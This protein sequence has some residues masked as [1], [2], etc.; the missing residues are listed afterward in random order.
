MCKC[1]HNV[2]IAFS[3]GQM[4]ILGRFYLLKI[5]VCCLDFV[6]NYKSLKVLRIFH[7]RKSRC[8]ITYIE[9]TGII[10]TH[11]QISC[12]VLGILKK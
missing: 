2:C 4:D 7:I 8:K 12:N 9:C 10:R 6:N 11:I 3:L 1:R 5:T